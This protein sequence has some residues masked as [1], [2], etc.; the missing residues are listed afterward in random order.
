MRTKGDEMPNWCVAVIGED[1]HR[2]VLDRY[3]SRERAEELRRMLLSC[4][5]FRQ[6]AVER[7]RRVEVVSQSPVWCDEVQ[8]PSLRR[9]AEASLPALH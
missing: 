5:V 6:V 9:R 4:N 2:V 1:G 7:E 8:P 3:L